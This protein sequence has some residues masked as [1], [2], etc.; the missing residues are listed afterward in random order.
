MLQVLLPPQTSGLNEFEHTLFHDLFSTLD[1][2]FPSDPYKDN[3]VVK[4]SHGP[5]LALAENLP[6]YFHRDYQEKGLIKALKTGLP[7]ANIVQGLSGSG[8]TTMLQHLARTARQMFGR[9]DTSCEADRV[10]IV[11]DYGAAEGRKNPT[12]TQVL[13]NLAKQMK[14]ALNVDDDVPA[15]LEN[16]RA[17]LVAMFNHATRARGR[18][19]VFIDAL[20]SVDN[21]SGASW[22]PNEAEIP[23][24]VQFFL[25]IRR[26]DRHHDFVEESA[27]PVPFKMPALEYNLISSY[28]HRMA[29]L[30]HIALDSSCPMAMKNST[31]LE[32]LKYEDRKMYAQRFLRPLGIHLTHTVSMQ[33]MEK[34]CTGN[35]R[36]LYL[37]CSRIAMQDCLLYTS[38]SPRDKRQSRMPSSA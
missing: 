29:K 24:G 26:I 32:V 33:M 20:H 15:S 21:E 16:V 23:I 9:V 37:T 31:M 22:L 4:A 12:P 8:T 25:G 35:L 10:V 11:S 19:L 7:T 14:S 6:F 27:H 18:V 13:R 3:V 38:P 17:A 5:E 30:Q 1:G 28:R 36:G 34:P 2:E